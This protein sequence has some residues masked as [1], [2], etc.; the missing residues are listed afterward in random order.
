MN[1]MKCRS[2]ILLLGLGLTTTELHAGSATWNLNPLSGDWNT[3]ANWTPATVP[4]SAVDVA[5]FSV[6]NQTSVSLSANAQAIVT[7][8]A[9][10]SAYTITAPGGTILTLSGVNN[11]S[12]VMQEF[13]AAQDVNAVG[14][15]ISLA[16]GS[17]TALTHFDIHGSNV[18][19]VFPAPKL[20][21][22]GVASGGNANFDMEASSL[23]HTDG[24][25][26]FFYD[27]SSAGSGTWTIHASPTQDGVPADL[28]FFNSSSAGSATINGEGASFPG[29]VGGALFFNDTT[30]AGSSTIT[31]NGGLTR[32]A[33]LAVIQFGSSATAGSATLIA[34]GGAGLGGAIRFAG[35]S[36]GGTSHIKLLGNGY[37]DITQE[38][39]TGITIG[40]LEGQGPALLGSRNLSVGSNSLSTTYS[41]ILQDGGL[42]GGS[43][44][45]L[46][47]VGTGT[48]TLTGAS[49]Y[50]GGTTVNSGILVVNNRRG[51]GTGTGPVHVNVGRFGGKG[52]VSGA[53]TIGTGSGAGAVLMP[54]IGTSQ[55]VTLTLQSSVTFNS[56][57][58]LSYVLNSSLST[59]D[60][61]IANGVVING[62]KFVL[63][64]KRN[65][66][67]PAGT[68]LTVIDN[69]SATPIAGTF[70]NLA[71]G[72]TLS[73]GSNTY[74][75]S[76][77]GGDGN[78]LV[79]TV[80]P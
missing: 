76:Y 60:R 27:S 77:E 4:N 5:S 47:K 37:L 3:P 52:I 44:G 32:S 74:Q 10:A 11:N 49:T 35:S 17:G 50:T 54:E 31:V 12:G 8:N 68:V 23:K 45:A 25:H 59:A 66:T 46:T 73:S 36:T 53:V 51:S 2:L 40:S 22:H 65:G 20:E 28:L 9:G 26:A 7:F 34:N 62:G 67:L 56:D 69:T 39:L 79:L 1:Y 19:N 70:S 80:V 43:G 64:D 71:D 58:T 42:A 30:S 72:T 21:L 15:V 33:G 78:D 16:N 38:T 55:Q 6:S 29:A 75:V 24:S 41:G 48:L 63:R 61:V 14:A 13:V 18:P 57:S